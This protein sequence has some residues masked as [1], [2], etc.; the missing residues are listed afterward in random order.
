MNGRILELAKNPAIFQISD[1]ELLKSEIN[2]HPYL[3]S[4]RALHL[5]GTHR[6]KPENYAQELSITAAYTTDKK[7]LYQLINSAH[8]IKPAPEVA[9]K[10]T[11]E[12]QVFPVEPK[13]KFTEII[14]VQVDAPKP[15]FV[16]GELNRILFEGEEDFLEKE[17]DK[18]DLESTIKSGQIVIQKAVPTENSTKKTE[19]S[20]PKVNKTFSEET[21]INDEI[22]SDQKEIIE[23][24]TEISFHE[25]EEFLPD[26]KTENTTEN[27]NTNELPEATESEDAESF[28]KETIVAED[29][30]SE[31]KPVIE[32][33]SELSFHATAEFLPEVKITPNRAKPE[34]AEPA[35][36]SVNKHEEQMKR[37]IAEVEAKMKTAKKSKS[38]ES[39]N[40]ENSAE[41]NF[42]ETQRFE[43]L[44]EPEITTNEV[45]TEKEPA[46]N[47][48][49][50]IE[51]KT[52]IQSAEI[53]KETIETPQET[54]QEKKSDWKPM[55]LSFNTPDG[56]ISKKTEETNAKNDNIQSVETPPVKEEEISAPKEDNES[57][58]RPVFNVSFFTQNVSALNRKEDTPVVT[59]Q[60]KDTEIQEESNVPIF[61]NTWQSWLKIDRS[62]QEAKDKIEISITE[63]K[64]KVIENFIEKE[65]RISKLKEESDFVIKERNDD[66]S[67]LMTETL[68][69]LYTEQKLYGKA[70]KAY[71]LLSEKHP[72][73]KPHFD[74]KIKQIKEFRQNK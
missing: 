34:V 13:N 4:L 67:H 55:S 23:N 26:V 14:S 66:I 60:E 73:K 28:S 25:T 39:E 10:Y 11:F 27:Y 63:I 8:E 54:P 53:K 71:G 62:K 59:E 50:L 61:I 21:I 51:E 74:E 47:K 65:P 58:E 43:L 49:L 70:I 42:S 40:T 20:E 37:L 69:N 31:E 24:P 19:V 6:L 64:N 68:A 56:L 38:E 52:K 48:D 12:K 44:Q 18:I 7:I 15:V 22:I 1:L 16:K 5:L 35:K 2:R 41:V 72:D 30:I 33:L 57:V 17:T 32:D 46:E 36:P 9:P 45:I 29:C 3:Q